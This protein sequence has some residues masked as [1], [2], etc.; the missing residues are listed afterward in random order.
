MKNQKEEKDH[1]IRAEEKRKVRKNLTTINNKKKREREKRKQNK[2][3]GK[4][5]DDMTRENIEERK[6]LYCITEQLA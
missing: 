3:Y 4:S 6:D 2:Q 1:R 5:P